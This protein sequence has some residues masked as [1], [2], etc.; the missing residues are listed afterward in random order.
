MLSAY[1]LECLQEVEWKWWTG[2]KGVTQPYLGFGALFLRQ[3]HTHPAATPTRVRSNAVATAPRAVP[4]AMAAFP[5]N[6]H[7]VVTI[8]PAVLPPLPLPVLTTV[9]DMVLLWLAITVALVL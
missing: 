1:L 6:L 9:W 7:S 4:M 8:S 3:D 5:P 2:S